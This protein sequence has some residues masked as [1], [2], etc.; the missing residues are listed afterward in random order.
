MFISNYYNLCCFGLISPCEISISPWLIFPGKL[1]LICVL[2]LLNLLTRI[3]PAP[4]KNVY[5]PSSG[6]P[7]R[8]W[9]ESSPYLLSYQ[10]WSRSFV[11][12][13][14]KNKLRFLFL[15]AFDGGSSSD[16]C[17][18]SNCK[19]SFHQK[20]QALKIYHSWFH[21]DQTYPRYYPPQ[22]H[23]IMDILT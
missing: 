18:T 22:Y 17:G 2:H 9:L 7:F 14:F 5:R 19:S 11:F 1:T 4:K 12:K 15:L 23:L 16:K 20:T 8:W 6:S 10:N 21:S 13:G 3:T